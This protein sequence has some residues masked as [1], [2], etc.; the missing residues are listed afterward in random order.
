MSACGQSL[1]VAPIHEDNL[2]VGFVNFPFPPLASIESFY[3]WSRQRKEMD[4]PK[5]SPVGRP[6]NERRCGI[7]GEHCD[8]E[9]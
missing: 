8:D 9:P 6:E 5:T 3:G 7:G 1:A 4:G 2:G